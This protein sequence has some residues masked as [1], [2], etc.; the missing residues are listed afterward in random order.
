MKP[1]AVNEETS[2]L[3]W[4][5]IEGYCML[6]L[7]HRP[8]SFFLSFFLSFFRDPISYAALP[9]PLPSSPNPTQTHLKQAKQSK[10][11]TNLN[12]LPPLQ[13]RA[14]FI[15]PLL[16]R[17]L[18]LHLL[19]HLILHAPVAHHAHRRVLLLLLLLL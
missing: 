5:N 1:R 10:D 3:G 13:P 18:L 12:H 8:F 2:L 9:F 4:C 7:V 11:Q 15:P 14:K 19:K 6:N 16:L 17:N